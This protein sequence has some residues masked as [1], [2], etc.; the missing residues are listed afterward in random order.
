MIGNKINHYI[1]HLMGFIFGKLT[2]FIP[3]FI[4]GGLLYLLTPEREG[5]VPPKDEFMTLISVFIY[6]NLDIIDWL[7]WI[8]Y[9]LVLATIDMYPLQ[10]IKS[11]I[12]ATFFVIMG[13]VYYLFVYRGF[14]SFLLFSVHYI[15]IVFYIIT[16]IKILPKIYK[17]LSETEL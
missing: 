8:V 13:F 11:I 7:F 6:E 3:T 2:L 1:W 17:F 12:K 14:E 9:G 10:P 15:V 5:Y 4:V 16:L